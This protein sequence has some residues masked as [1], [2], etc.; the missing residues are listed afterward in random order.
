MS[1]SSLTFTHKCQRSTPNFCQVKPTLL[2][3]R[4]RATLCEKHWGWSGFHALPLSEAQQF[5]HLVWVVRGVKKVGVL[6]VGKTAPTKLQ[7]KPPRLNTDTSIPARLPCSAKGSS[8]EEMRVLTTHTG[9]SA[10]R[11]WEPPPRG[12]ILESKPLGEQRLQNQVRN[13]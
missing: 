2:G 5:H 1:V 13:P 10:L 6:S 7:D 8:A 9:N 11:A 4:R 12:W 3:Q